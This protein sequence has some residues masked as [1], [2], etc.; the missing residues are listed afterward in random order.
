MML[1]AFLIGF[2]IAVLF[3]GSA[4]YLYVYLIS[5]DLPDHWH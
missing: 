2:A 3:L 1:A 5:H 4:A